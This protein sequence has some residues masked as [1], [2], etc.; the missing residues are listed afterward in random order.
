MRRGRSEFVSLL[1]DH[2]NGK[3]VTLSDDV[4]VLGFFEN[5][6]HWLEEAH[7]MKSWYITNLAGS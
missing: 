4:P 5:V 7:S 3:D 2:W 1:R 6:G